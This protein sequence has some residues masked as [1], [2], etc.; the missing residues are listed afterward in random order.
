MASPFC[1]SAREISFKE[2]GDETPV[3]SR[4]SLVGY[5]L[6]LSEFFVSVVGKRAARRAQRKQSLSL[7][8]LEGERSHRL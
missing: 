8:A 5:L 2:V 4:P 1:R 3:K 7:I 6:G